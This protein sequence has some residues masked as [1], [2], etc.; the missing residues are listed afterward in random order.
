[1]EPELP[2]TVGCEVGRVFQ[3]GRS[4]C[5]TLRLSWFHQGKAKMVFLREAQRAVPW[6]KPVFRNLGALLKG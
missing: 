5:A 1:M 4:M 6:D 3:T 2:M